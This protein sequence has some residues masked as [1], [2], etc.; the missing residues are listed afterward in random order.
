[1][2]TESSFTATSAHLA[3]LILGIHETMA[4]EPESAHLSAKPR[5]P[6]QCKGID[7]GGTRVSDTCI[8]KNSGSC[9]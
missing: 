6:R 4:G 3:A 7:G 8:H 2:T 5:N 9:I 1:M